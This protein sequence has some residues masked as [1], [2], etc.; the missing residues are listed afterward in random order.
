M[1]IVFL[2][3]WLLIVL[4]SI[5]S[6]FCYYLGFF[7]EIFIKDTSYLCNVIYILFLVGT[8]WCGWNTWQVS[9]KK[10]FKIEN[11]LEIGWFIS[12]LCLTIGMIGTVIGFIIMFSGEYLSNINPDN[13]Q[14]IMS[15]IGSVANGM[16]TALYTTLV[17][18]I[19]SSLL[20]I[21][22]F[23]LEYHLNKK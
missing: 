20:K 3:W 6:I 2:R 13:A 17:G 18:L 7:K 23:N 10:N 12:E 22:Y 5:A 9:N 11:N 14:S 15:L 19:C 4:I 8:V 1:K 16:S 21:Q